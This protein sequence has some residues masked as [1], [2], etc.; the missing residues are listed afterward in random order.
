M[1]TSTHLWVFPS[2]RATSYIPL[3]LLSRVLKHLS[4]ACPSNLVSIQVRHRSMRSGDYLQRVA[5]PD[6]QVLPSA[7]NP[8]AGPVQCRWGWC[9]QKIIC[10]NHPLVSCG[11]HAQVS[12]GWLPKQTRDVLGIFPASNLRCPHPLNLLQIL[13]RSVLPFSQG[14]CIGLELAIL[15]LTQEA[16]FDSLPEFAKAKAAEQISDREAAISK[17]PIDVNTYA[18][19]DRPIQINTL[20]TGS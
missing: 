16:V 3:T 7:N 2:Y 12:H 5:Q 1:T 11:S 18:L 15:K 8:P 6:R 19:G 14:L 10:S 17:N 13:I 20:T 4:M 9:L